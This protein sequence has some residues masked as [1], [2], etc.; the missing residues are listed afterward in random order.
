MKATEIKKEVLEY[1]IS[2]LQVSLMRL[3]INAKLSVNTK[4]DYR[5]SDYLA[6]ESEEFQTMPVMFKKVYLTGTIAVTDE[7]EDSTII[8]IRLHYNWHSFGGGSN[9]TELGVAY[10]EIEELPEDLN[11]RY[12]RNYVTKKRGL[13]I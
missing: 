5:G 3:G 9:G 2:D 6:I 7:K 4:K 1:I 10:Y 13:E 11:P 12:I 8:S